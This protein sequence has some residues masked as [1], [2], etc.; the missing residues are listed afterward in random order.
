MVLSPY[1]SRI[2]IFLRKSKYINKN[3]F[4]AIQGMMFNFFDI[5]GASGIVME[6][7]KFPQ[8]IK[9][10]PVKLMSQKALYNLFGNISFRKTS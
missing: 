9:S 1:A 3:A 2:L 4:K 7:A 5:F 8:F 6:M 10:F